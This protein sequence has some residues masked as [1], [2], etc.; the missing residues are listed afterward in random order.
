M[1]SFH[2]KRQ[3]AILILFFF[4]MSIFLGMCSDRKTEK[5]FNIVLITIDTLRA[6]HLSCYGYN[7]NTSPNID[8]IAEQGI[9]YANAIAP[10]PWTA[11]SMVSLFTSVYPL[12]HGVIHGFVK[13]KKVFKQEVF[14]DE[15][16]TLAEILKKHGYAT[17]GV[18]S[19]H[20]LSGEFG[21]ARGFDYF[22]YLPSLS[23]QYVNNAVLPWK[24]KIKEVDKFFLW[25]HYYDPHHGYNPR[26]PWANQYTPESLTQQLQ[27][28]KKRMV[29]LTKNIPFFRENPQALSNLIALYD[30]EINYVDFYLGKLINDF[31]LDKNSLM[32]ITSDHGEEFLE[33]GRLSHAHNLY[34]ETINIPLIVKMPDSK[35]KTV[36]ESSVNLIDIMPT[37]LHLLGINSPEYVAGKSFLAE[38]GLVS[39]KKGISVTKG[40]DYDF[41]ELDRHTILKSIMTREWKY[42]YNFKHKTEQLYNI[43]SDPSEL[44]NLV[45]KEINQSERLKE[46]LFNWITKTK[47][48]PTKKKGFQLTTEEKEKLEGLGYIQ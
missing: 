47:K 44:D 48:Y 11:P 5:D 36:I 18:A 19:N 31:E 34:G 13:E 2:S 3:P 22:T 45:G 16:L 4:L 20:H 23:A 27:L 9:I 30:S 15:L 25:I 28:Y 38:E 40:P 29:D 12:S 39:G 43:K 8:K 21:F 35:T 33:H 41:A 42:I 6:D 26:N 14:S 24:S 17:F 7:R 1:K 10:S 37:I 46:E 32:I